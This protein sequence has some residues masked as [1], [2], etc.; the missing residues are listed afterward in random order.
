MV[1]RCG[2]EGRRA[3]HA[4]ARHDSRAWMQALSK[5]KNSFVA[6][7]YPA[8]LTHAGGIRAFVQENSGFG[9]EGGGGGCWAEQGDRWLI[10]AGSG[11]VK[12]CL[13]TR[14]AASQR[15]HG[16]LKGPESELTLVLQETR[17]NLDGVFRRTQTRIWRADGGP[18]GSVTEVG[19]MRNGDEKSKRRSRAPVSRRSSPKRPRLNLENKDHVNSL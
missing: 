17:S 13:S 10:D 6:P 14:S 18:L 2:G 1:R 5:K 7:A 3:D 9:S 15:P 8:P 11:Q 19:E 12:W 4:A 16:G